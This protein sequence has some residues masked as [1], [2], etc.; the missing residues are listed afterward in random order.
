MRFM[1]GFYEIHDE[2]QR[3]ATVV[4]RKSEITPCSPLLD[5]RQMPLPGSSAANFLLHLTLQ[6]PKKLLTST[7]FASLHDI[8]T[9]FVG[10]RQVARRHPEMHAYL[11]LAFCKWLLH[12]DQALAVPDQIAQALGGAGLV[13]SVA[14]QAEEE[15]WLEAALSCL[16]Q[17]VA[18]SENVPEAQQQ[19]AR[20]ATQLVSGEGQVEARAGP[21]AFLAAL[22]ARLH[23]GPHGS[24]PEVVARVA[25]TAK[26]WAV[27]W[28]R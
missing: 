6:A 2:L 4:S 27:T 18:L 26:S 19:L 1:G 5:L 3:S 14:D 16:D 13:L 22:Q 12:D 25:E 11:C 20:A 15:G 21:S 28:T 23:A 24:H 8:A 17:A 10:L 7:A 9:K